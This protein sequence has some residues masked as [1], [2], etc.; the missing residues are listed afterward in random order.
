LKHR[1]L[2]LSAA[3]AESPTQSLLAR[4]AITLCLL[5]GGLWCAAA[6]LGRWWCGRALAP[7]TE[8]A[9]AARHM[10]P[11]AWKDRLPNP[12]TVD[13]LA[14]LGM[15]FN[16]LLTRLEDAF[17]R[18]RRFTG[19]ASHQ[20]RTPLTAI[21]GQIDVALRRQ[22]TAE[23]YREVLSLVHRQAEHLCRIVESLLFLAR[24]DGE[25]QLPSLETIDLAVWLPEYVK[26]WTDHARGADIHV[27]TVEESLWVNAHS[28]LLEQLFDNLLDNA[29]KYSAPGTTVRV[30]MSQTGETAVCAIEDA[31]CGI[32][33]A[34]LPRIFDPFFRSTD[35][36]S[37]GS[38]GIGLGLAVAKRIATA[39]SGTME[40][41][42]R[43]GE[44]SCFS[45][46]LPCLMRAPQPQLTQ[47]MPT[48]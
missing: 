22:R 30:R 20:L 17:D 26:R 12:G 32:A 35:A 18:Q 16:D 11:A 25:N 45:L 43:R 7:L 34:D 46:R 5:S 48:S 2:V 44:G 37:Q 39:L 38:N 36:R 40:V 33:S 9:A 24:A 3:I 6:V 29:F 23:E 13:E 10:S 27:E 19:D 8:M 28:P 15:A 47:P 42:S 14:D 31:G 21:L 1:I 41:R 4:L